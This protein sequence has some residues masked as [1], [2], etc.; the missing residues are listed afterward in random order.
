[1]P[2]VQFSEPVNARIGAGPTIGGTV[3][4]VG[5]IFPPVPKDGT[6]VPRA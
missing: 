1:L 6:N 5:P 4:V 2:L 3:E